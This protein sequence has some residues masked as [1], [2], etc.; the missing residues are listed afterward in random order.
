MAAIHIPGAY[1][2]QAD[3]AGYTQVSKMGT[4][5]ASVSPREAI[6][7]LFNTAG[8]DLSHILAGGTHPE[9]PIPASVRIELEHATDS[10][11]GRLGGLQART[12]SVVQPGPAGRAAGA[13]ARVRAALAKLA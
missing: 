13:T 6:T 4:T 9:N 3:K 2:Q 11:R 12:G 5:R 8:G 1:R 10:V 7:A